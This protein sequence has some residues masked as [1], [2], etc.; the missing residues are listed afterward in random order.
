MA[1]ETSVLIRL[2]K[3]SW[4]FPDL[5]LKGRLGRTFEFSD[6]EF[7]S[8]L[9]C[10]VKLKQGEQLPSRVFVVEIYPGG[11]R[12]GKEWRLIYPRLVPG[13]KG[14]ATFLGF[15]GRPERLVLRGDW[16]GEWQSAY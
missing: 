2:P 3:D 8:G 12:R 14:K 13:E 5:E 10:T 11:E 16:R 6:C 4:G 9:T 1:A 7:I 15:R